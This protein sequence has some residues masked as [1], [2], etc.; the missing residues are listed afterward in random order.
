[1]DCFIKRSIK[2][3]TEKLIPYRTLQLHCENIEKPFLICLLATSF[4]MKRDGKE[5]TTRYMDNQSW[6][7]TDVN[8]HLEKKP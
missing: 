5:S 2:L 6:V 3:R 1:M 7:G 8:R 4:N